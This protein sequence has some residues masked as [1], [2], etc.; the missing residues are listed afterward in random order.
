MTEN[1]VSKSTWVDI[2]THCKSRGE[3]YS[4]LLPTVEFC[5]VKIGFK[6]LSMGLMDEAL[7]IAFRLNN[8]QIL[9]RAGMIARK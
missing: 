7:H 8:K 4:Y 2:V 3:T 9:A 6:L 1:K 5:I